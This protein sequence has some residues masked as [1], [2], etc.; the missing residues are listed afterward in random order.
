MRAT[1][2]ARW[3]DVGRAVDE[4]GCLGFI[5][6]P[7]LPFTCRR[8]YWLTGVPAERKR[9]GHGHRRLAQVI[10]ALAGSVT[11][12]VNDGEYSNDFPL[13]SGGQA[14]YIPPMRWRQLSAFESDSV[15]LILASETYDPDDYYYPVLPGDRYEQ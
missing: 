6:E 9:G 4:R 7:T 12:T 13:V 14:L 15:V 8:A 10:V 3:L 11:V 2:L 5:E 1:P